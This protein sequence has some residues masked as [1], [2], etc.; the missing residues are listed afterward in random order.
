MRFRCSLLIPNI[1]SD[2]LNEQD[3]SARQ[4]ISKYENIYV[5]FLF[6]MMFAVLV[7]EVCDRELVSSAANPYQSIWLYIWLGSKNLH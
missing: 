1:G 5:D 7:L 4:C 3:C 6:M 2:E